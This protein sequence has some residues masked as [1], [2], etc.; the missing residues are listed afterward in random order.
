M[1]NSSPE[2]ERNEAAYRSMKISVDKT[3]S[4]GRF[5]AFH[6][7]Q[8]VADAP[9]FDELLAVL[10]REGISARE[11]LVVQAGVEYPERA[12]IFLLSCK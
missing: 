5:V 6:E 9:D 11:S 8:I 12:I 3:Y 7:G 10:A 2:T 1:V 4:E